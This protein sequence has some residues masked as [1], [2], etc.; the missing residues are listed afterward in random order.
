[1]DLSF[2]ITLSFFSYSF[3]TYMNSIFML[4]SSN[5]EGCYSISFL[6][7]FVPLCTTSSFLEPLIGDD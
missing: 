6:K 2:F 7:L 4:I 5:I 1:M 3:S